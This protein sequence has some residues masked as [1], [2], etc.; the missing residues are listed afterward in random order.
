MEEHGSP[1]Q[2]PDQYSS[3]PRQP[4]R[5]K[6]G[7]LVIMV[8]SPIL[9]V[10][11]LILL[12]EN[13]SDDRWW[14]YGPIFLGLGSLAFFNVGRRL[15]APDAEEVMQHDTR[16][17]I[18]YLR[19]FQAD[20]RQTL[21]SPQGAREG[22]VHAQVSASTASWEDKL[23]K[24]LSSLGP[25]IA[26]GKPGEW[27]THAG[28]AARVYLSHEN[29]KEVVE[30]LVKRAAAVVLQPESTEGTLWEVGHVAS[31][32]D[33][34]RVLLIVPNP[35]TRPFGFVR[36]QALIADR[37]G[38][39]LPPIDECGA[40]DAFWFDVNRKPIPLSFAR[41]M[42]GTL[43]PFVHFVQELQGHPAVPA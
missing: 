10:F 13:V 42:T 41:D 2:P 24:A 12:L 35:A 34:R 16:P 5:S 20:D 27:L 19:S 29:W 25:F 4:L 18:V 17:P 37:F 3:S 8:L 33:L 30:S 7:G 15:R 23:R 21:G 28:G 32:I 9:G 14:I 43:T 26:V 22:G 38:V 11:L 31:A 6:L 36:V 40:C 39:E 1:S